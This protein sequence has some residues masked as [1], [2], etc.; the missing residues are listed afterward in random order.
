MTPVTSSNSLGLRRLV[1]TTRL[2][3]TPPDSTGQEESRPRHRAGLCVTVP[4]LPS[5]QRKVRRVDPRP[6]W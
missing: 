2:S 5:L 3:K 4:T 1:L 6:S